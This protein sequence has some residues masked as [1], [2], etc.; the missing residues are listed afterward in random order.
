MK[1][2]AQKATLWQRQ[3]NAQDN[4]AVMSK[5]RK[6]GMEINEV[7]AATKAEFRKIAHGVSPAV[8]KGF[9]PKGKEVVDTVVFFN[10]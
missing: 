5:L 2:A 6:E 3:A 7:P 4:E 8:V 1:V 10:K 9:G